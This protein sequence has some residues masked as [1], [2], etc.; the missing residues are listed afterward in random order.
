[1][2]G[3]L[4]AFAERLEFIDLTED[5][6]IWRYEPDLGPDGH[7][8][9]VPVLLPRRRGIG[10]P[11]RPP[12]RYRVQVTYFNPGDSTIVDGGMGS[13]AG[14]IIPYRQGDWPAADPTHPMYVED[15]ANVISGAHVDA[16]ELEMDEGQPTDPSARSPRR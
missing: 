15:Y 11:I 2:G 14:A 12:H 7:V 5:R 9:E 10:F 1:M 3:H 6:V 4:H 16:M 8:E 13:V